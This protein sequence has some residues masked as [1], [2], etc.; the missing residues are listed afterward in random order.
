M[1][2]DELQEQTREYFKSMPFAFM[3]KIGGKNGVCTLENR[4]YTIKDRDTSEEYI[5]NSIDSL[6]AAQW[7]I[8]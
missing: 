2:S 5:F 7:V 1:W 6:I 8:D 3:K 4:I